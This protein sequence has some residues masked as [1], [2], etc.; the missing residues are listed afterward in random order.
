MP[1]EIKTVTSDLSPGSQIN[2]NDEK[3]D[4]SDLSEADRAAQAAA[5]RE[6][7]GETSETVDAPDVEKT[8]TS[9]SPDIPTNTE[10]DDGY[11]KLDEGE[12]EEDQ[13]EETDEERI[14]R[15]KEEARREA[16]EEFNKKYKPN[17]QKGENIRLA[18]ENENLKAR[19]ESMTPTEYLI[20]KE[21][22]ETYSKFFDN[23]RD[24]FS[25]ES[26]QRLLAYQDTGDETLIYNDPDLKK[27]NDVL[28]TIAQANPENAN[29]D[30]AER[31]EKAKRIAFYDRLVAS[32]TR[33]EIARRE[34]DRQ[35]VDSS[36][37]SGVRTTSVQKPSGLTPAQQS[38][39]DAWGIK[40]N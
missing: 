30:L 9:D 28:V 16:W 14:A 24:I 40:P 38:V 34:M 22:N 39:F 35:R 31:L 6:M 2:S 26:K 17:D 19:V 37:E 33:Q 25:P 10:Y 7:T 29:V 3:V 18:K 5:E 27:L 23:S 36:V 12:E 15:L 13:G 8:G 4:M 32:A 20:E 11:V 1:E 21:K